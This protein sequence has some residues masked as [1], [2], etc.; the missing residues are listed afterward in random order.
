MALQNTLEN[1]RRKRCL[2]ARPLRRPALAFG[3]GLV[4]GLAFAEALTPLQLSG[5]PLA[6]ALLG[7]NLGVE[8]GQAL[9]ILALLPALHG[10]ARQR[11]ANTI[12]QTLSL[13]VAA[14]GVFWLVQRLAA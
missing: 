12:V 10:L 11:A 5:W 3:F 7:F 14:L 9:V 1:S 8:A 6:R 2:P 13:A 4:H